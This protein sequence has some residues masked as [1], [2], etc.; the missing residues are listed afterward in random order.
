MSIKTLNSGKKRTIKTIYIKKILF[1]IWLQVILLTIHIPNYSQITKSYQDSLLNQLLF[2]NDSLKSK[3]YTDLAYLYLD[4]TGNIAINF[5]QNALKFAKKF[6]NLNDIAYSHIMIGSSFLAKSNYSL[7]LDEFKKAI[8]YAESQKNYYQL[9]TIFNNIGIIYK[10][11][12]KYDLALEYYSKA[13]YN[14]SLCDDLQSVI[15]TYNNI[16]NIYVTQEDYENGLLYYNLSLETS[17]NLDDY[18]SH[19]PMI[20]NNIGYVYFSQKSFYEAEKYYIEAYRAFDSLDNKYGMAVILNNIAEIKILKKDFK[21]AEIL[22]FEADSLHSLMDY[23]DSRKNLY[24]TTY[25]LYKNSNKYDKALLFLE[26]YHNLNDS[27]YTSELSDKLSELETIH[28]VDK[29]KLQNQAKDIQIQKQKLTNQL[30]FIILSVLIISAIILIYLFKQKL[31]LNALLINTNNTLAAKDIIISE[32]LSYSRKLQE[33]FMNS[34]REFSEIEHFI[35]DKPKSIVG[36]DFY[37]IKNKTNKTFLACADST[38]HGVSGAL[39]S[40]LGIE[41]LSK[42]ISTYYTTSEILNNLNNR[43]LNYVTKSNDLGSE[44]LCISLISIEDNTI[45]FS[46]SKHKVWHYC[47]KTKILYEF[48]TDAHIIGNSTPHEFTKQTIKTTKGDIIFLSSDG[49]P[50]QF[51]DNDKGKYKYSRFRK[52]LEKCSGLEFSKIPM[53][54]DQELN[55]WCG[56]TEQ[57]DDILVIGIKIS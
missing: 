30:L 3:I 26:K 33:N 47:N 17:K 15:Q 38:G 28:S 43:F 36:G 22:I 8:P 25:Q 35:F 20:Y 13:L 39:L 31:K 10:I 29:I 1:S 16:G 49:Y 2:S 53:H 55:S 9:H 5:S 14:A 42:S 40:V 6:D 52:L 54:L 45:E 57:T 23:Q 37:L 48:K 44:S 21:E 4:S 24:Y 19:L 50:D 27:I 7:A 11:G 32:N 34:Y 41:Y 12:E 51:G 56:Q 46:G 18:C